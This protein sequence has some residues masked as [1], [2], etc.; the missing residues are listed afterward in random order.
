MFA[1]IGLANAFWGKCYGRGMGP[2][3]FIELGA[4]FF[5]PR[6]ELQLRQEVIESLC[7]D[8]GFSKGGPP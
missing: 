6:A 8:L 2:Q 1:G 4:E 5:L 7:S 3:K